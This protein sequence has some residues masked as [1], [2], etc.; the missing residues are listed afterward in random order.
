MDFLQASHEANERYSV[1]DGINI[2][3]YALKRLAE[4]REKMTSREQKKRIM[5]YMKESA[6]LILDP[7]AAE[8]FQDVL[9][10]HDE[11]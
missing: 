3:R 9:G 2:A 1:R 8:Y 5:E 4:S 11:E 7:V 10:D 6:N